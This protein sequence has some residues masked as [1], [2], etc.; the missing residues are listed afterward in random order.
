MKDKIIILL[1]SFAI[2]LFIL[3]LIASKVLFVLIVL[4]FIIILGYIFNPL[5]LNTL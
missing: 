2:G 4:G 1:S 5:R 3:F